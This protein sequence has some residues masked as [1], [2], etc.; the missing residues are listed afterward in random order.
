MTFERE[1][2]YIV[3]KRSDIDKWLGDFG[4]SEL[5]YWTSRIKSQRQCVVVESD[6]PEYETVWK[7]IEDRVSK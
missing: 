5:L 2:R 1:D 6:W 4:K 3:I 7:M